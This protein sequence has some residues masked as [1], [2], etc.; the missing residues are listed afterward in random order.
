MKRYPYVSHSVTHMTIEF[1]PGFATIMTFKQVREFIG[2]LE[3]VLGDDDV[4]K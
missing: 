1:S 3:M 4:R 2:L